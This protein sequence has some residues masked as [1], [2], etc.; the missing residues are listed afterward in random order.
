MS[1]LSM[2]NLLCCPFS[3]ANPAFGKPIE[4]AFVLLYLV[5]DL[6]ILMKFSYAML[7]RDTYIH[8]IIE[9]AG[10]AFLHYSSEVQHLCVRPPDS[11]IPP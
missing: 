7:K 8:I 9:R 2:P 6:S 1:A 4:Q 3:E 11:F 5:I 10:E